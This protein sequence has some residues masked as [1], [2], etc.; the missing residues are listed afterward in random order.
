MA[1]EF[2]SLIY[3]TTD[4]AQDAVAGQHITNQLAIEWLNCVPS[5]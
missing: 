4:C 1:D 5:T 2:E 3:L